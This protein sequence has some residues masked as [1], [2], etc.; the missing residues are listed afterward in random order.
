MQIYSP[1]MCRHIGSDQCLSI[2]QGWPC[3]SM[4]RKRGESFKGALL[5]SAHTELSYVCVLQVRNKTLDPAL[6]VH[7][8]N[9]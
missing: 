4:D 8:F 2:S 5:L 7:H 3:V 6:P 9:L 1:K